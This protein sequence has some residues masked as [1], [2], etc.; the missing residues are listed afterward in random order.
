MEGVAILPE[1]IIEIKK[2][3]ATTNSTGQLNIQFDNGKD[4][5]EDNIYT[6]AFIELDG[7]E[8]NLIGNR[9]FIGASWESF[10][11]TS[12]I[13][14]KCFNCGAQLTANGK[15]NIYIEDLNIIQLIII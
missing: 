10:E 11:C 8:N 12:S 15:I 13:F 7:T 14:T 4:T 3:E 5:S 6:I 2:F 1:E 9:V